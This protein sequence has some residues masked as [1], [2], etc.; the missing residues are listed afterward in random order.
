MVDLLVFGASEGG[1]GHAVADC[2][3]GEGWNVATA[4]PE[5]D[6]D[7]RFAWPELTIE[8]IFDNLE[9]APRHLVC[10]VGVN[11]YGNETWMH[12][13]LM[14]NAFIPLRILQLWAHRFGSGGGHGVAI[15]SNSAQVPRSNSVGYCASK[16]ALSQGVRALARTLAKEGWDE[17]VWV[18][19]PGIVE[20]T[21]MTDHLGLLH[22]IPGGRTLRAP[23]LADVIVSN[24]V[25]GYP[26]LN[27]TTLRLDGGEM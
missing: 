7:V 27:G 17:S 14:V 21:P 10:A 24:L 25:S 4:G 26:W 23:E 15:S 1:I 11:L 18:V 6:H 9:A 22:R 16:A 3:R 19:E 5:P 8:S 2:A 13:E 12:H 20:D